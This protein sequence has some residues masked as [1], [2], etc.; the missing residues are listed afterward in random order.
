MTMRPSCIL[1]IDQSTSGTKGL[2]VDSTGEIIGKSAKAHQQDYPQPGWVEHDPYE[3]Y[4][5][6]KEV[7]KRISH[8]AQLLNVDIAA[9]ALTN[10]RETVVVWEKA[11]GKIIYPAIVWQCKRTIDICTSLQLE[12]W[13]QVVREKTGLPI[14]PYFSA[15]KVKW[16][17]DHVDGARD[18]ATEGKLL[19]GT[20]DSWLIWN[21]T[22]GE[23]HATDSTNASRTML[24]NI[25]TMDWD[26]SL[27]ELFSIPREM[28]PEVKASTAVF[29]RLKDRSITSEAWQITGVIGDSQAALFGQQC[30]KEGAVKATFGTGTS[31]MMPAKLLKTPEKGMITSVGWDLNGSVQYVLEGVINSTGDVFNWL[32]NEVG[33]VKTLDEAETLAASI[34]NNGGVY[35]VPAFAGLGTPYWSPNS[36]AAIVGMH[37]S[38]SKAHLARAATEA[39]AYQVTDI[40]HFLSQASTNEIT[41]IHVDGGGT[42]NHLLMQYQADMLQ[43]PVFVSSIK[44]VSALGAAYLAGLSIGV[45]GST[46]ELPNPKRDVHIFNPKMPVADMKSFYSGWRKAVN[47]VLRHAEGE[48]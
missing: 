28:M 12:G 42:S 9:L 14:D 26:D 18:K 1:V 8:R 20:I 45:W 6:V 37:R 10:Q 23:V 29:G 31:V 11:T 15:T 5:N 2:L 47:S 30:F 39:V 44:E 48:E 43:I 35:F 40:V 4:E 13:E 16:I 17:L 3:L 24:F 41:E 22:Q 27:L 36:R 46:D 7:I 38:S 21:L 32:I 25:H 33:I 19:C 34:E